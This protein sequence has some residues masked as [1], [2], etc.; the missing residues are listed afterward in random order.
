MLTKCADPRGDIIMSLRSSSESDNNSVALAFGWTGMSF[1][2]NPHRR[3]T[4]MRQTRVR[5]KK[6]FATSSRSSHFTTDDDQERVPQ[7]SMAVQPG[8]R[9]IN[10]NVKIQ[11]LTVRLE[12]V[13][14]KQSTLQILP[15]QK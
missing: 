15:A 12:F 6:A 8:I 11:L 13:L 5:S 14:I 1:E 3:S 2:Q 10:V 9:N 7:K 4:R